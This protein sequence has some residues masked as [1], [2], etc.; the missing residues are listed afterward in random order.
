MVLMVWKAEED[1]KTIW[2]PFPEEKSVRTG[3][4]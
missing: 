2:C 4:N 1:L 3:L